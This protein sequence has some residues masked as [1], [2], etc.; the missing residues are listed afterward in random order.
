[1]SP[2]DLGQL[3]HAVFGQ[4]LL[5]W[6]LWLGLAVLT[7]GLAILMRTRWGQSQPLSKC[8]A[9]SLLA[10]LLMAGYGTTV[11]IVHQTLEATGSRAVRITHV[12]GVR[13][14]DDGLGAAEAT[15]VGARNPWD[16]SEAT[17]PDD[18]GRPQAPQQESA[19]V[20]VEQPAPVAEPLAPLEQP[21]IADVESDLA[22]PRLKLDPNDEATTPEAQ[23]AAEL[24]TTEAEARVDAPPTTNDAAIAPT[25]AALSPAPMTP[26]EILSNDASAANDGMNDPESANKRTELGSAPSVPPAPV[27]PDDVP[28]A[29]PLANVVRPNDGAG[30]RPASQPPSLS[31]ASDPA[32]P[33]IVPAPYQERLGDRL[34]MAEHHG[35]SAETEKAVN[36][37]LAWLASHQN[38]DGRWQAARYGAGRE[39]KVGGQDRNGAGAGADSGV[40]G[41]AL[42]AML[43]AGN[44]QLQGEHREVVRK[45]LEYLIGIQAENGSLGG[46]ATI[47]ER[48]YC[49]AMA[50]LAIGEAFGLSA[51]KR[52]Q[53][54][55]R[56]AINFTLTAQDPNT[57]GWRY[58]PHEPG[59]TSQLGWQLMSLRSAE[60]AQVA[61]PRKTK[62]GVT[63]FLSS[64]AHGNYGGLACYRPGEQSSRTMTAEAL[65]CRQ[66]LGAP[67][68]ASTVREAADFVV[69]ELPTTGKSNLYYWYYATLAL[70]Q[71]QG[72]AWQ[73]WN[74]ALKSALVHAQRGDGDMAG[75]WD[76]N[77][78]WG[79]YGGRVYTT[80]MGAL[81]LEV[82]YRYLPLYGQVIAREAGGKPLR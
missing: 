16:V 29:S 12:D 31:P 11:Q 67:L 42:L 60:L 44:T 50:T 9:L 15:S 53:E 2:F 45:G 71:Q 21:A 27:L 28:L 75:S 65:A 81:C 13:A 14:A 23:P 55:L 24:A 38:S 41:L 5:W 76:T 68:D 62:D 56:R 36:A 48:M 4:Q 7:V 58:L 3:W 33:R 46:R 79:G 61:I 39:L 34:Q 35:G 22:D 6:G 64:V 43:G 82:Y 18:I 78:V 25:T 73:R 80:A 74:S 30:Q 47:N 52:L 19:E 51:D 20:T 8:L 72:E 70:Y 17:R 63:K 40:T 69:Q 66:F 77:D 57:G 37:A 1:M 54:P 49:H 26:A 32:P 59:D 10:H